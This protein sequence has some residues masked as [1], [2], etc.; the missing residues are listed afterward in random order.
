MTRTLLRSLFACLLLPV[1]LSGCGWFGDKLD[2]QKNWT[3]EQFYKNARDELESGNFAGAI[4]LYEAL[5]ARY[6]FGRYT[7]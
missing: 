2:L 5:E 4:K 7:Q 6:P 1:F 3:V